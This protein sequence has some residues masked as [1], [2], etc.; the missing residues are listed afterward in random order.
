LHPVG[1][2]I[3]FLSSDIHKFGILTL[4]LSIIQNA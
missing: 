4:T 2:F 1:N 3:A